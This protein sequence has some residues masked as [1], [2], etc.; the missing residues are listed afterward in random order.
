MYNSGMKVPLYTSY[1]AIHKN[2]TIQTPEGELPAVSISVRPPN[3]FN[4]DHYSPLAPT[5]D[6]VNRYKSGKIDQRQYTKEYLA[7]LK[8]NANIEKILKTFKHGAVF[9]CYEKPTDFCHR[10]IAAVWVH[11]QSGLYVP[12]LSMINVDN[13]V[14]F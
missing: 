13:F 1:Y 2:P 6:L 5:W 7:L 4:G 12:E 9:L 11:E 14:V 8:A 10:Q 3:W